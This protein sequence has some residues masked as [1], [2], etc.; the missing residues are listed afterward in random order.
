M[1]PKLQR[2]FNRESTL[3][4]LN[5]KGQ[6]LV[7][8]ALILA[9]CTIIGYGVHELDFDK[10]LNDV[11]DNTVESSLT[12]TFDDTKGQVTPV[13]SGDNSSETP[14]GNNNNNNEDN[15]ENDNNSQNNNENN[16]NNNQDNNEN[17]ASNN[18][19][20]DNNSG[21]NTGGGS[22]V[23]QPVYAA[24]PQPVSIEDTIDK[25]RTAYDAYQEF[26]DPNKNSWDNLKDLADI[27]RERW[28][29]SK[30]ATG[31]VA[32]IISIAKGNRD[33]VRAEING[34]GNMDLYWKTQLL[35]DCAKWAPEPIDLEIGAAIVSKM[36]PFVDEYAA[37][38]RANNPNKTEAEVLNAASW[39]AAQQVADADSEL[40]NLITY[41]G[42]DKDKDTGASLN[43]QVRYWYLQSVYLSPYDV[44][45]WNVGM[46]YW[47]IKAKNYDWRAKLSADSGETIDFATRKD[48]V[49]SWIKKNFYNWTTPVSA[50]MSKGDIVKE[51]DNYYVV[52]QDYT[53]SNEN[54]TVSTM[55]TWSRFKKLNGIYRGSED[56]WLHS[57]KKTYYNTVK[58]G[59][60]II[61]D[62]GD[63]YVTLESETQWYQYPLTE[64]SQ[65]VVKLNL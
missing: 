37:S 35:Y 64:N 5:N 56:T 63:A 4:Y 9:F 62:N 15:N 50:V 19:D 24:P 29:I 59:T 12:V 31:S 6:G 45:S 23:T 36:K 57:D 30:Y 49:D 41:D 32:S 18:D 16:N 43:G 58:A 28:G 20:E 14:P 26:K 51:G 21:G 46:T 54:N 42:A 60:I 48:E 47:R 7:E 10:V 33:T 3:S 25:M 55:E 34:D 13:S 2:I 52:T 22:T 65:G 11:F 53:Y 17:S 39:Y 40:K 44:S 8:F 1:V 61:T 38:Y 27:L